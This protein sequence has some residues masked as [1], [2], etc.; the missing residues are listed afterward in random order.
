MAAYDSD[1][2]R[3]PAPGDGTIPDFMT[4]PARTNERA[5]ALRQQAPQLAIER[6]R[7]S[8]RGNHRHRLHALADKVQLDLVTRRRKSVLRRNLGR[9]FED[10]CDE[11]LESRCLG[12]QR[13]LVI[14][15]PPD[16]GLT[17]P[18]RPYLEDLSRVRHPA[19]FR[20]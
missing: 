8:R 3:E 6:C 14:G 20:V 19:L 5:A 2:H 10:P 7:H 13:Q 1:W 4:A 18:L 12:G 11:L 17:V 16:G 9:D 15:A